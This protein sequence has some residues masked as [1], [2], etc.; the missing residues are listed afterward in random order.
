MILCGVYLIVGVWWGHQWG[1]YPDAE[2]R[3]SWGKELGENRTLAIL[4]CIV[5]VIMAV[6]FWPFIV[7]AARKEA[8]RRLR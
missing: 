5:A 8:K 7:W 6:F 4:V 2:T 3:A 1:W